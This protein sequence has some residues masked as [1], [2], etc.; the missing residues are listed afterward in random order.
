MQAENPKLTPDQWGVEPNPI[1]A[2]CE[3]IK[4]PVLLTDIAQS[5]RQ[6]MHWIAI[7]GHPAPEAHLDV[8]NA[9]AQ[10]VDESFTSAALLV[11]E[12]ISCV[13]LSVIDLSD[14]NGRK[15]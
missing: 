9:L 4:M 12:D 5:R 14:F 6:R 11:R 15:P 8:L 1:Q 10:C 3:T 13:Y 2:L 7:P